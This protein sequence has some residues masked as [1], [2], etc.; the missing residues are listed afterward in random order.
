MKNVYITHKGEKVKSYGEQ[1]IADYLSFHGIEYWYEASFEREDGGFNKPDFYLPHLDVW[2]EYFGC[3][4]YDKKY[5]CEM[6][7]KKKT[8]ARLGLKVIPVFKNQILDHNL[9]F[10]LRDKFYKLTGQSLNHKTQMLEM[11]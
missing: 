6:H 1:E 9:D 11:S 5:N 7:R 3:Y 8:F 2:I 10:Y 4:N